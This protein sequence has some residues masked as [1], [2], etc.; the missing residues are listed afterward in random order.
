M[1][2][3]TFIHISGPAGLLETIYLPAQGQARGV[4]VINHPNPLQ[5]GTNTNKVIQTAAKALTQLSF[6]CYLPN[7][8]GVGNSQGEHDYGRGETDDCLAV[9]DYAR[10]QHPD[11]P[12]FALAGFSFGGYVATFA[13]QARTPDL[14][15]LM[16]P[17]VHHYRDRPEPQAVPDVTK[18]LLIHG[19]ED[20]VV[21]IGKALAWA[22]PQDLPVIAIAGSSHFFHGKLIALRD[23]ILRFAPAVLQ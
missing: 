6:H 14:L 22:E 13:A 12:E 23:T 9:I 16:G 20:E 3:P 4:A 2:K 10:A 11:A 17:A 8:R 21:E 1:L 18:T 19:A 7:L 5:G 15:L